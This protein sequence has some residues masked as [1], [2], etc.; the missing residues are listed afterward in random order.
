VYRRDGAGDAVVEDDLD[1]V[2][3]VLL[4]SAAHG[5]ARGGGPCRRSS[6]LVEQVVYS[7]G[8]DGTHRHDASP[9]Q[10]ATASESSTI[11][12]HF[13]ALLYW[14]SCLLSTQTRVLTPK[15]PHLIRRY[16]QRRRVPATGAE[17]RRALKGGRSLEAR[18]CL[19]PASADR[20]ASL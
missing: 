16:S 1:A 17:T 19:G 20:W 10:E 9:F 13:Q 7:P 6:D 4:L 5:R 3:Q 14:L 15:R 11:C 18:A 8:G 12:W 2:D